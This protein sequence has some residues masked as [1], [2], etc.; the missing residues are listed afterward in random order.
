MQR[1]RQNPVGWGV[2]LGAT[3]A[4]VSLFFI[5]IEV[6]SAAGASQRFRAIAS[7][8]G[9]ML[10]SAALIAALAGAGIAASTSGWRTVFALL[11][12]A[13]GS[14]LVAA[15]AWA[16]LDSAGFTKFAADAQAF[17]SMTASWERRNASASLSKAFASGDLSA[18]ARIGAMIGLAGGALTVLGSILSFWRKLSRAA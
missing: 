12:L 4:T 11:A 7:F 17:A 14:L 2:S 6:V 16:V 18:S 3:I 10:L 8:T 5:W 1:L 9:Q 13:M 15:A